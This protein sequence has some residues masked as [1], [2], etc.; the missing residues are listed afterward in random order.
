MTKYMVF[1]WGRRVRGNKDNPL[2]RFLGTTSDLVEETEAS[3]AQEPD[4]WQTFGTK[5]VPG[6]AKFSEYL[7][8]GKERD[9]IFA[10][11]YDHIGG[12]ELGNVL[13][14]YMEIKERQHG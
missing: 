8:N 11:S 9:V 1:D 12:V 10:V 3:P 13:L 7:L 4:N 2:V 14:A 5:N 6:K